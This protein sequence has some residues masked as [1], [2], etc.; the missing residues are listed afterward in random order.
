MAE[1][2]RKSRA[3]ARMTEGQR[4]AYCAESLRRMHERNRVWRECRNKACKRHRRCNGDS[5][6]RT[7]QFPTIANRMLE[8]LK[9][10]RDGCSSSEAKLA[11]DTA[12]AR[13]IRWVRD[14]MRR[15]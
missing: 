7:R 3:P 10:L 5:H 1:P 15:R 9:A 2:R 4:L 12:I 6:D 13:N 14:E 11:V 8:A